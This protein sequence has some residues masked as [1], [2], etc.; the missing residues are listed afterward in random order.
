MITVFIVAIGL[1]VLSIVFFNYIYDDTEPV[2]TAQPTPTRKYIIFMISDGFGP[3]SETFARYMNPNKTNLP[4]DDMLVGHVK[5][6]TS[7]KYVPPSSNH[8][9]FNTEVMWY[10]VII[11][12]SNGKEKK[13]III[14]IIILRE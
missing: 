3:S 10:I 9:Y 7:Q 11:M 4:L 8:H 1:S 12:I 5:T 6:Y 14:V 13:L 2:Q